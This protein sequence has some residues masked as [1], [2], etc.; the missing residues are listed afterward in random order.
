MQTR[1]LPVGVAA[2]L[3]TL[4]RKSVHGA[5]VVRLPSFSTANS[6]LW[7]PELD[8]ESYD[9]VL[10]ARPVWYLCIDRTEGS[11]AIPRHAA[12]PSLL[13]DGDPPVVTVEIKCNAIR[14]IPHG[15]WVVE[16]E[17]PGEKLTVVID[18]AK[19]L[20]LPLLGKEWHLR[21]GPREQA[22]R[23]AHFTFIKRNRT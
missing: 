19:D 21:F 8:A 16:A 17:L 13:R 10:A 15:D 1:P 23:V 9:A 5:P 6:T 7:D 22:H 4:R 3:S 12:E 20:P 14:L 2:G 11:T 18:G